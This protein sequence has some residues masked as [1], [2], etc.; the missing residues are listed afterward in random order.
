[1]NTSKNLNFTYPFWIKILGVILILT[2]LGVFLFR[3]NVYEIEDFIGFSSP[4]SFGLMMIFF[5]KER[6]TD[7][8]TIYLKFKSLALAVPLAA[9]L[10]SIY[11]YSKN[12]KAYRI[13]IDNWYSISA[14]EYLS[15]TMLIAL[16]T[17]HFL[18]AR[19]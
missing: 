5:S 17:F 2:G 3:S 7:E 12:F 8:R 4:L 9:I 13:N 14:F 1:M 15:I 18:K 11:N 6:V 19:D 16:V 10:A